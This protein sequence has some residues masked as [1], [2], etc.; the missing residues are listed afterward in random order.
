MQQIKL[1]IR[2][3][4]GAHKYSV[5]YRIVSL[6]PRC[7]RNLLAASN[8]HCKAQ[9]FSNSSCVV[10]TFVH[11]Q[12]ALVQSVNSSL[13]V[14]NTF[15]PLLLLLGTKSEVEQRDTVVEVDLQLGTLLPVLYKSKQPQ[16]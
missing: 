11:K 16:R 15:A 12:H 2:Q 7:T 1:A 5:S 13:A 8:V 6:N 4:F 3:F 10:V 9:T 14:S